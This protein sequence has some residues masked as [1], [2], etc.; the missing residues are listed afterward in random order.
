MNKPLEYPEIA[1]LYKAKF[2]NYPQPMPRTLGAGS[3]LKHAIDHG[4]YD[5][6]VA[7]M[8]AAIESGKQM[9]FDAFAVMLNERSVATPKAPIG[10]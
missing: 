2:D 5:E 9:D 3:S 7:N 4:A 10:A 8:Q 6:L 1:R